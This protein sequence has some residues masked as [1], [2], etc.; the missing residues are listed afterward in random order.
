MFM[1]NMYLCRLILNDSGKYGKIQKNIARHPQN[2]PFR[3]I[4][5]PLY[6]AI[7]QRFKQ[8]R[9]S[10]DFLIDVVSQQPSRVALHYAFGS[11]NCGGR[12]YS[13]RPG[14]TSAEVHPLQT[15]LLHDVLLRDGLLLS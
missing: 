8:R 11:G 5:N 13:R 10:D 1:K 12:P 7:N 3:R 9:H 6:M 2:N 15:S 4:G 14:G